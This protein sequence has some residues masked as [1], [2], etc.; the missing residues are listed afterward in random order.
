MNI[1]VSAYKITVCLA[2]LDYIIHIYISSVI[3]Q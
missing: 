3:I 1:D 2:W